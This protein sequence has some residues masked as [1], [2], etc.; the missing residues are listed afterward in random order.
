LIQKTGDGRMAR[1][2]ISAFTSLM[3]AA[4]VITLML[5]PRNVQGIRF[6]RRYVP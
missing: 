6:S 2:F 3:A 5:A 1:S 4:M